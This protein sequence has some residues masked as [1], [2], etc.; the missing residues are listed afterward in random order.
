MSDDGITIRALET[1]EDLAACVALQRDTWGR[2]FADVVPPSILK[3][4]QRIGGVAAGAFD[5][6]G[7]LVGFV[8]GMT[9]LENGVVVHWSDMLAVRPSVQNRG[10]GRRLK[11]FQRQ[12][13]ERAGG[14]TIYWTF[15]PLVAR[16]AHINFNVFGVSAV[17][18]AQDMY[19]RVTGSTLHRGI[20][21]DRLIV[22]WSVDKSRHEE[23]RRASA[24]ARDAAESA[25]APVLGD[26]DRPGGP[27][28]GRERLMRA[29]IAVPD[30]IE[31]MLVKDEQRAV[32]WR[33]S[34]RDAFTACWAAG[35]RVDGFRLDS[36]HNRG[37]YLLSRP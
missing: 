9:G 26:I 16:N 17:E 4:T 30:D 10:I 28:I 14:T 3:V 20:G 12:A 15:D 5:R 33:E 22:A 1:Q 6:A 31:T 34:T 29:R 36:G 21:T 18:Y 23:R 8:F 27:P 32:A 13:V 7:H 19:G 2:G 11:E 25:A 37:F 24:A 35:L